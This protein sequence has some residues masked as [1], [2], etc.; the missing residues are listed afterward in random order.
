MVDWCSYAILS[1][2]LALL[3]VAAAGLV[4]EWWHTRPAR[5][6]ERDRE[7]ANAADQYAAR[8]KDH[9]KAN[10]L[11]EFWAS[12]NGQF[13]SHMPVTIKDSVRIQPLEPVSKDPL[14]TGQLSFQLDET[15]M[16]VVDFDLTSP[17]RTWRTLL[18]NLAIW[19]V[20]RRWLSGRPIA[21]RSHYLLDNEVDYTPDPSRQGAPATGR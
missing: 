1:V 3:A 13:V 19:L 20:Q 21:G 5:R 6:A 12:P 4:F 9:R 2:G 14:A 18:N 10:E 17:R 8:R 11:R 15:R 16:A 7:L